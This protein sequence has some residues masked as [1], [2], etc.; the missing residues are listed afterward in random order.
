LFHAKMMQQSRPPA[1]IVIDG[2]VSFEVSQYFPFHHHL[3]V[4]KDTDF[5]LYFTDSPVRRSGRMTPFQKRRRQEL[6][7]LYG[8][9]DP[10]AV[11]KDVTELL[12]VVCGRQPSVVIHSDDHRAYPRAIEALTGDMR[13]I[14]TSSQERRDNHNK[15]WAVNLLD[16]LIRHS[17]ANHKRETIAWSKRRQA[18][19]ERLAIFL[20]WRNYVKG[21]REKVRGSPTPAMARGMCE[22]PLTVDEILSE[23]IFPTRLE[24]PPRWRA[25]YERAVETCALDVNRVHGLKYAA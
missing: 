14:V 16:L 4:E 15:L 6:E 23:R 13:H 11:M 3:A 2:F 18:S 22:G 1:E 20:V 24:L 9:P 5:L 12:Q 10:Q 19:A 25:Y 7:T 21:R 8:R 17:S